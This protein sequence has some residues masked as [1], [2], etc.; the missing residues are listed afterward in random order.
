MEEK[1]I[2]IQETIIN[3]KNISI[4]EKET[5]LGSPTIRVKLNNGELLVIVFAPDIAPDHVNKT[6]DEIFDKICEKLEV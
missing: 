3:I 2:K 5:I 1:F 6:R 4:I